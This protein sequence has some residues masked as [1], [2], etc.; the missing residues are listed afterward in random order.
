MVILSGIF[1]LV[2]K[3]IFIILAVGA[4]LFFTFM[5]WAVGGFI[6]SSEVNNKQ[7]MISF[8]SEKYDDG[9]ISMKEFKALRRLLSY[10]VFDPMDYMPPECRDEFFSIRKFLK[11]NGIN[12]S[13][14]HLDKEKTFSVMLD[15]LEKSHDM[16]KP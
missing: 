12:R 1:I 7:L 6:S 2:I 16:T 15:Y 4:V 14:K 9:E 5:L 8:I 3:W 10:W 13:A 11:D